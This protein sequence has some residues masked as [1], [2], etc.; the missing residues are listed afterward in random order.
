MQCFSDRFLW[1]AIRL[2]RLFFQL[3]GLFQIESASAAYSSTVRY[4]GPPPPASPKIAFR[5]EYFT[6]FTSSL[7][8]AVELTFILAVIAEMVG[9]SAAQNSEGWMKVLHSSQRS[10]FKYCLHEY[11]DIYISV[12]S[13]A[14]DSNWSS[15]PKRVLQTVTCQRRVIRSSVRKP[16]VTLPVN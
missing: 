4:F 8:S 7:L 2:Q 14:R 16:A 3:I 15:T 10:G 12:Y 5:S 1:T 9:R 13:D 11:R 6:L